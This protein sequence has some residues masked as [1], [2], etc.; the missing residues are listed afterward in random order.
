MKNNPVLQNTMVGVLGGF[1]LLFGDEASDKA[2]RP[3]PGAQLLSAKVSFNGPHKGTLILAS[4]KAFSDLIS[5]NADEDNHIRT[6]NI[7]H[8]ALREFIN[9][10]CGNYLAEAYGNK[11]LHTI[12]TPVVEQITLKEWD[13]FFLKGEDGFIIEGN[14]VITAVITE[15]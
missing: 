14:P 4:T 6:G 5:S 7:N 2:L 15:N 13:E 3:A 10:A 11:V 9:I 12:E 8:D 1:A